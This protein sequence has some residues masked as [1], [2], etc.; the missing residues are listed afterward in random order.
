M[1]ETIFASE[2]DEGIEAMGERGNQLIAQ[3]AMQRPIAGTL[4]DG[5]GD[6]LARFV[7]DSEH[8]TERC[9]EIEAQFRSRTGAS[10]RL[11]DANGIT[12]EVLLVVESGITESRN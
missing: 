4:F 8:P 2:L 7:L 10:L 12:A 6:E 9:A 3:L 5:F 1:I 11:V